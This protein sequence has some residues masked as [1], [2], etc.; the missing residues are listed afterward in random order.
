MRVGCQLTRWTSLPWS[1]IVVSPAIGFRGFR[2]SDWLDDSFLVE[3][4]FNRWLVTSEF[5]VSTELHDRLEL[6]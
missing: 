4:D 5:V 2:G 6:F 1:V 3:V